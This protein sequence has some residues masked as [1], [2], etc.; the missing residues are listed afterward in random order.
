MALKAENRA[1][2][3]DNLNKNIQKNTAKKWV[4]IIQII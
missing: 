4:K 3:L 2:G 1:R